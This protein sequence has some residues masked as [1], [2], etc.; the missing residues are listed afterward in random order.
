MSQ[1]NLLLLGPPGSGKGTQAELLTDRLGI[2]QIATGDI[3]REAV[4]SGSEIGRRAKSIMELGELVPDEV[5][6]QIVEERLGQDDCK[7]GFILDGFPR[8]RDQAHALDVLL[9]KSGREPLRA[10]SLKVDEAVLRE[11]ILKRG[12]GRVD[13][14]E[15]TIRKRLEVYDEQ[16]APVLEHYRSVLIEVDGMGSIEE[17]QLRI[18]EALSR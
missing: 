1:Q 10:V 18:L 15:A 2:P 14:N 5:V 17:I 12:E 9:E 6:I 7:G 13:D 4:G 3:L 11:R 8:T 16:T